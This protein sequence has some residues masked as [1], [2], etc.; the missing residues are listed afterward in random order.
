MTNFHVNYFTN[1]SWLTIVFFICRCT[2]QLQTCKCTLITTGKTLLSFRKVS[3]GS[4]LLR[5]ALLL[6]ASS[7]VK[8]PRISTAEDLDALILSRIR[9][10][11]VSRGL[12]NSGLFIWTFPKL[13]TRYYT[14]Q[15]VS[16]ND[17]I[18]L[19]SLQ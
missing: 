19:K 18:W 16:W 10:I 2:Y 9:L 7:P 3:K 5:A 8:G 14:K 17:K 13:I 11:W 15:H 1:N 6:I 4:G 12:L